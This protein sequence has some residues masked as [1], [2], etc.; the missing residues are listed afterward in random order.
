MVEL[1]ANNANGE[2]GIDL[3]NRALSD[4]FD[5]PPLKRRAKD[6]IP[7][8][9]LLAM[10]VVLTSMVFIVNDPSWIKWVVGLVL[11]FNILVAARVALS[12]ASRPPMF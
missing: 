10:A 1:Q 2:S 4:S 8:I 5:K 11:A 7:S 6:I 3:S 12:K 9:G